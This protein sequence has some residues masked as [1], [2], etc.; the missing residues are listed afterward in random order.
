MNNERVEGKGEA[1]D[2]ERYINV[3]GSVFVLDEGVTLVAKVPI[4]VVSQVLQEVWLPRS[5]IVGAIHY[6][7]NGDEGQGSALLARW[8]PAISRMR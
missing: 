7:D 1:Q 6:L 8:F 5:L 4:H 2:N 3:S